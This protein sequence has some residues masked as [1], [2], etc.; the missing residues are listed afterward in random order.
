MCVYQKRAS[1]ALELELQ[2]L[3]S[4]QVGCW[5]LNGVLGKSSHALNH[6]ACSPAPRIDFQ[7]LLVIYQSSYFYKLPI[8]L[9]LINL[10][11]N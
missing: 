3:R 2:V 11:V 9:F 1:D 7:Y 5:E 4:R 6:C 10:P 8:L